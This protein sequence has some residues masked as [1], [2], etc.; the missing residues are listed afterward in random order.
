MSES[1]SR[2]EQLQRILEELFGDEEIGG[3][4]VS[5]DLGSI[6]AYVYIDEDPHLQVYELDRQTNTYELKQMHGLGRPKL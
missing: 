1:G 4:T 3:L 2:E 6:Q 5:E